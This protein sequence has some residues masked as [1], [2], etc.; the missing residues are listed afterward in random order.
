MLRDIVVMNADFSDPISY[1]EQRMI[2]SAESG[3]C[4]SKSLS[5]FWICAVICW[6]P[7]IKEVLCLILK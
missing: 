2:R 7:I 4:G 3:T 6:S 5:A 1:N